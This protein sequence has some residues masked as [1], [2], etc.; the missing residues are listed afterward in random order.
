M[1]V[2]PEVKPETE[3]EAAVRR[4]RNEIGWRQWALDHALI[5]RDRSKPLDAAFV[6]AEAMLAWMFKK[7]PT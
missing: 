3:I 7:W 1:T 6:D 2:L 5:A 4:V